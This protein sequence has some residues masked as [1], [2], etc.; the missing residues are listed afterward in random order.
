MIDFS[1]KNEDVFH[2]IYPVYAKEFLFGSSYEDFASMVQEKFKLN[3]M[4]WE[5]ILNHWDE[6]ETLLTR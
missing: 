3:S 2:V 4:Q 5:Y 6:K 1:K